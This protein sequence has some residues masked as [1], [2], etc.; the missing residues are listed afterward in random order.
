M[1]ALDLAI[2]ILLAT[3]LVFA[4]IELGL[5]SYIVTISYVLIPNTANR[6]LPNGSINPNAPVYWRQ[7]YPPGEVSYLVFNSVWTIMTI[8]L[9]IAIPFIRHRFSDR[10]M[11]ITTLVLNVLTMI[12]WFS[13]FI[14]LSALY[15]GRAASG[16]PG[17]LMAFAVMLWYAQSCCNKYPSLHH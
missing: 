8:P 14:A 7:N 10:L 11:G 3:A 16:I 4:I 15:N 13:G 2:I 1:L 6:Y 9:L 5:S 12:F 17:A